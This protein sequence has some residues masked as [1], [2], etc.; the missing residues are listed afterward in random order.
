MRTKYGEYPEYHTS[1]DNFKVVTKKGLTDS[2]KPIKKIIEN[3]N[4]KTIPVAIHKCEPFLSK[5]NLYPKIST[6]K[7]ETFYQNLLDFIVYSDGKNS[8]EEIGKII[9]VEKKNLKRI[10]NILLKNNLIY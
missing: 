6:G 2:Y 8:L 10:Y 1:E 9:K 7:I 3:L 4:K 5:R